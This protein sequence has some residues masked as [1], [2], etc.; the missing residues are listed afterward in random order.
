[1]RSISRSFADLGPRFRNFLGIELVRIPSGRCVIGAGEGDRD[2]EDNERPAHG[3]EVERPFYLAANSVTLGSYLELRD[4]PRREHGAFRDEHAVN[5]ISWDAAE[6]YIAQLNAVRPVSE[7]CMQYRL[8][9]EN[10]WEYACRA[11]A[12]TRFHYGDD[13]GYERLKE[14]AWYGTNAWDAGL[15]HPQPVGLKTPNDYGLHDMHGNVWEWT[16]DGWATYEDIVRC[17]EGVRDATTRVL[18]GGGFCHE[19]RYIR[20]SDRDHY[21]PSYCHYYTGFRICMDVLERL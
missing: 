16:S 18:R 4:Y 9:S 19:A 21:P 3:V 13:E 6:S 10:E 7:R 2:A 8:P 14:Y 11:G 12:S 5:F 17:G 1:M 15:R 20:A